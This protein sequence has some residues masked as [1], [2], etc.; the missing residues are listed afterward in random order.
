[1]KL[2][3]KI[4]WYINGLNFDCR[5]C[6]SC[7]SGPGEGYIWVTKQEIRLIADFLKMTE[8]KLRSKYLRRIG[9]RTTI[10]E[11]P[12][13]K[14]CIFLQEI[15]GIRKCVI[16]PVRPNQCRTWP[17]WPENLKSPNVWN[18]TTKKCPGVN[19]GK[20]FSFEE[21][22]KIRKSKWYLDAT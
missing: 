21:I 11:E 10:I 3:D 14:D 22:E 18:E 17:F 13:T 12:T 19:R 7:C 15:E 9:F 6:G 20:A 16:Y 8:D 1:M 5:Q 2:K 4:P